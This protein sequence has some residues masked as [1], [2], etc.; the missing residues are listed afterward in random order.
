MPRS[1]NQLV[2]FVV[3][4]SVFVGSMTLGDEPDRPK[5][6]KEFAESLSGA[7]LTGTY[8]VT[9]KEG[10]KESAPKTEKYTISKV[11]KLKDDFWLIQSRIQ[12]G[13][14]DVNVPLTL[15]IK[16][17]GDT[18]IITMTDVAVPGLGTFTA[19]VM[20]YRGRYAGTWQHDKVGGHLWGTFEK[21]KPGDGTTKSTDKP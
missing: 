4:W 14:H 12:Y 5:L 7:V 10:A 2:A 11:T 17:A 8:S 21:P 9:G 13:D 19:R 18:P 3:V 1:A 16:W 20:F 15:E 6:E